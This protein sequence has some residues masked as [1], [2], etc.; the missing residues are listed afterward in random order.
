[1]HRNTV[2]SLSFRTLQNILFFSLQ[3]KRN[4]ILTD[5]VVLNKF[6]STTIKYSI[7]FN[8]IELLA[9]WVYMLRFIL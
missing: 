2:L 8:E 4:S 9:I 5:R 3:L 7:L 6:S 1:M